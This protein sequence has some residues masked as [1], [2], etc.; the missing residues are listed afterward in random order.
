MYFPKLFVPT[1]VLLIVPGIGSA[2]A[3]QPQ[4][5]RVPPD[6]IVG[7]PCEYSEIPGTAVITD[8]RKPPADAYNCPNGA[9]EVVFSF[10]P[11]N[12]KK[13][14]TY[15]FK[16]W[17]DQGQTLTV[18]GG[19]NPPAT[20]VK[21]RGLVK[22]SKHDCVRAEIIRGSCTAVVFTFPKVDMTGWEKDCWKKP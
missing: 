7:G 1:F 11:K 15:R 19:M 20:W 9:V 5:D 13:R 6:R 18:G 21:A 22:G 2:D 4:P 12:P 8:V 14:K 16:N 17:K 3:A 10:T